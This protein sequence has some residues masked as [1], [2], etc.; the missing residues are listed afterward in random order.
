M[1]HVQAR[2]VE[3][4]PRNQSREAELAARL[5]PSYKL[6]S[7]LHKEGLD[8]QIAT[9]IFENKLE[10]STSDLLALAPGVNKI[11][12]RKAK[13]Q[14]VK[15]RQRSSTQVFNVNAEGEEIEELKGR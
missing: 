5:G 4:I 15:P 13:N 14:Q 1:D 12:L 10:I 2:V 3:P 7:E 8:E 11:M 9:L 6:L